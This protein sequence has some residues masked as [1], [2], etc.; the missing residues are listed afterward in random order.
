MGED[1]PISLGVLGDEPLTTVTP[2]A[3]AAALFGGGAALAISEEPVG[4]SPTGAPTG[5][6][7]GVGT[8]IAL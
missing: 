3:Q 6:I 8:L 4:G 1:A 7:L 5:D 2:D